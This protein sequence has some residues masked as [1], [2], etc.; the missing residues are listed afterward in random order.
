[1]KKI[2]VPVD[3]SDVTEPVLN[4]ATTLAKALGAQ[5][6][7]LHVSSPIVEG[8]AA[9]LGNSDFSN[10]GIPGGNFGV[11][12]R[13]DVL[14]DQIAAELKQEHA[15]LIELKKSLDPALDTR[16]I[17]VRG[18]I[19]DGILR[20][21]EEHGADMVVMG[22]HGHGFFHKALLGSISEAI[23]DSGKL[24]VLVIPALKED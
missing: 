21:A 12:M 24:P 14:R 2:L 9:E 5:L 1:M 15:Q 8:V 16:I 18:D 7:L 10:L 4:H 6:I 3:F 11:Y 19:V 13:Y 17:L 22:S 20:E 23:V